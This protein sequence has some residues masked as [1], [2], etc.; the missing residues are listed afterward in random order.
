MDAEQVLFLVLFVALGLFALFFLVLFVGGL[1]AARRSGGPGEV[2]PTPAGLGIGFVANFFDTL[3]IG[4]FAT[5]TSAY[6]FW[7]L[8]R[9][10]WIP[11]TLNVGHTLPTL[12]QAFIYTAIVPVDAATLLA[13]IAA[14]VVGSWL[15]AGVVAGLPR[16]MIQFGMG[17]ALIV[18]ATL[19]LLTNLKA[20]PGGGEA[21]GLTGPLLVAGIVGNFVLG[22]LMPLGIGLYGPCLILIS[23]LGMNPKSAFP[24]MMGSCAFLM[25]VASARFIK[26]QSWDPRAALG[27]ALGGIPAVFIAAKIVKELEL[28]TVRWLV[29][30]VVLYAAQG[31]LRAGLRA[32]RFRTFDVLGGDAEAVARMLQEVYK[33]APE[34]RITVSGP[35]TVLVFAGP[36]ELQEIARL[37]DGLSPGSQQQPPNPGPD[38]I[39]G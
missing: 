35:K 37:I 31:L 26:K 4:S 7:H 39:S 5:T 23:L 11:G 18:A 16:R 27:L 30:A 24:I 2:K 25:P 38:Q 8:V 19:M 12:V 9:D 28:E 14:S 13:L 17:G 22:A 6:R 21:L 10:E 36:Q 32:Q 34:V 15:G 33:K 3:G 29:V 1:L 20:V